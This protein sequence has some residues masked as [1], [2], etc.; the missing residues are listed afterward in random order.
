MKLFISALLLLAGIF[1]AQMTISQAQENDS[2][3]I[4]VK[5]STPN[6]LPHEGIM[7]NSTSAIPLTPD[8]SEV[9]SISLPI[10]TNLPP[11]AVSPNPTSPMPLLREQDRYLLEAQP[12]ND[13]SNLQPG[14]SPEDPELKRK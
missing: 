3:M 4:N 1:I 10:P 7:P 2:E 11:D 14:T 8:E 13:S 12:P 6:T 9:T 5:L